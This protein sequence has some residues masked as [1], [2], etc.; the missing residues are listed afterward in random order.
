[1]KKTLLAVV[2]CLSFN[3]VADTLIDA[4]IERLQRASRNGDIDRLSYAEK[5]MVKQS[6]D[7]AISVLR[8]DVRP[9]PNPI[10]SNPYPSYPQN[11]IPSN[12]GPGNG[13]DWRRHSSFNR[14]EVVAFSDDN[15]RQQITEVKPRE[16]C[17]RLSVIFGTQRAWSVSVNG[18]CVDIADTTFGRICP[19]LQNLADDQKPRTE[20]LIVYSSDNCGQ[21]S[22]TAVIDPG[23][24]CNAL[25]TVLSNTR[26]WSVRLNGQ[27][28]DINDR[29]MSPNVCQQ[30][31]DGVLAD[32]DSAGN[33]RRG[34]QVEMFSDDRCGTPV[35]TVKRGMNCQALNGIFANQRVWSVRFRGQCVDINDTTFLPACQSYAQ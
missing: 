34:D 23:V 33:R 17:D 22:R 15:C 4:R 3:V 10:P 16:N 2:A 21:G 28:V 5:D 18:Q 1:M 35:Y 12:P 13:G 29:Q 31:Q 25:G 8:D 30:F 19:Q 26:A 20:D 32:Y 11:P 14:N 27:C 9:M 7:Q 24:D 6:L